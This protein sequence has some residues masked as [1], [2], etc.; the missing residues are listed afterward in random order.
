MGYI[1]AFIKEM[2]RMKKTFL[3]VLALLFI[4]NSAFAATIYK[5]VGPDGRV[6][7]KDR[8]CNLGDDSQVIAAP[9]KGRDIVASD[10]LNARE[11]NTYMY[12]MDFDG[13]ARSDMRK[14]TAVIDVV[15]IK[16]RE[17]DW[18][19]K[20]S[21]KLEKCQEFLPYFL[22]GSVYNQ[23]LERVLELTEPEMKM[24]SVQY[25]SLFR[26]VDEIVSVKDLLDN[27]LKAL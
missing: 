21:K 4:S 13:D 19:I 26:K 27:Y 6:E 17:C 5:C 24:L 2:S 15:R 12:K 3:A 9:S 20:V 16:A 23:S 14:A 1:P 8:D 25:R 22:E 10:V 11:Q 7:F 18:S